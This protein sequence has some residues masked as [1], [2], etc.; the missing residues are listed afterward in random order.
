MV[1]DACGNQP[2]VLVAVER[3][4][5]VCDDDDARKNSPPC[6]QVASHLFIKIAMNFQ[7]SSFR[8]AGPVALPPNDYMQTSGN[9]E[10]QRRAYFRVMAHETSQQ[11]YA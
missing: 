4:A 3:I 6:G 11:Q 10:T 5:V 7:H 9:M 8:A 2:S 1:S